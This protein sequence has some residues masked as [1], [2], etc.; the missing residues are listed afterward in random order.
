MGIVDLLGL[1]ISTKYPRTTFPSHPIP[2]Y[3]IH[4]SSRYHRQ[5][6][7]IILNHPATS[8]SPPS[9]KGRPTPP[10]PKPTSSSQPFTHQKSPPPP[11][12]SCKPHTPLAHQTQ[13]SNHSYSHSRQY[14]LHTPR[15]HLRSRCRRK[16]HTGQTKKRRSRTRTH[17]LRSGA[18]M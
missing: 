17:R 3:E 1:P 12:Y 14:R 7:L 11:W 9:S 8:P 18:R 6:P 10:N 2:S 15:D 5:N 4:R 13:T 16:S